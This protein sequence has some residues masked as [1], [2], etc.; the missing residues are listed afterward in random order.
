MDVEGRSYATGLRL[1]AWGARTSPAKRMQ[2]SC[3]RETFLLTLRGR[4]PRRPGSLRPIV[5]LRLRR[6]RRGRRR[7]PVGALG[8]GFHMVDDEELQRLDLS[9][10]DAIVIGPGA[11]S[12]RAELRAAAPRLLDYMDGGGTLIVQYQPYG[13]QAP[14]M[15]P[16]PSATASP[17]TASQTRGPASASSR[18]STP[19]SRCPTRSGTRTSTAG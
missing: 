12:A 2:A 11:Y 13:Y 4:S 1:C 5:A 7:T 10:F 18:P 17:T 19:S 16:Y 9:R 3:I 15:A 8:V 6:R 14:G